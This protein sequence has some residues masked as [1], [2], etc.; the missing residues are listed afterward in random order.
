[1]KCPR[2]G[3]EIR[4]QIQLTLDLPLLR[5]GGLD[6]TRVRVT[7]EVLKGKWVERGPVFPVHCS[8]CL[9]TFT[10]QS[11]SGLRSSDPAQSKGEESVSVVPALKPRFTLRGWSK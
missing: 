9:R 10:Y 1:M 11:G 8:K 5:R 6:L 4:G 7:K 3:G 2:C